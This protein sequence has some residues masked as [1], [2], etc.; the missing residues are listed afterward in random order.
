M[1]HILKGRL[2]GVVEKAKREK[3][4]KKVVKSTIEKKT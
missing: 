4:I 1:T 2:K 3:A